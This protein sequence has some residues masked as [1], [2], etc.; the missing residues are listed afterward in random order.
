MWNI[1]QLWLYYVR[2]YWNI[3]EDERLCLTIDYVCIVLG[4]IDFILFYLF[5]Y[6][7]FVWKFGFDILLNILAINNLMFTI[8]YFSYQSNNYPGKTECYLWYLIMYTW[9]YNIVIFVLQR[10]NPNLN[11]NNTEIDMVLNQL[12]KKLHTRGM[13]MFALLIHSEWF[14]N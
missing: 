6:N 13:I 2:Q 1:Y 12:H 5:K 11:K 9:P 7:T 14:Q 10:K 4:Y 8:I 3:L